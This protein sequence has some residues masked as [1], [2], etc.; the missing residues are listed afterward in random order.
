MLS[1]NEETW[2]RSTRGEPEVV[3]RTA[4]INLIRYQ[5]PNIVWLQDQKDGALKKRFVFY[6]LLVV[7]IL[8]MVVLFFKYIKLRSNNE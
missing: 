6:T 4:K 7:D 3:F 8:F 5:R 1:Y 2:F